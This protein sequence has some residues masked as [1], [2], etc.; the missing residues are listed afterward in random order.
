MHLV[1]STVKSFNRISW[2]FEK[3][4]YSNQHATYK[5]NDVHN[6]CLYRYSENVEYVYVVELKYQKYAYMYEHVVH[7]CLCFIS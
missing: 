2:E 5:S 1:Q 7:V 6:I 3:L 4:I